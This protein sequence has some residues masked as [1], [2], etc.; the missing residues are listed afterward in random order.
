MNQFNLLKTP[1]K[2]KLLMIKYF[3]RKDHIWKETKCKIR[4][5]VGN[6]ASLASKI[7]SQKSQMSAVAF[8]CCKLLKIYFDFGFGFLEQK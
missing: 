6:N 8:K 5:R 7:I 2:S 3:L 4:F 1:F